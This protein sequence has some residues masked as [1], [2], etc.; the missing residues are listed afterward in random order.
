[1]FDFQ[2]LLTA[3]GW[4][5]LLT[6]I[7]LEM[8]LGIDNLVFIAITTDRLPNNRKVIGRRFGLAAALA[9]RVILLCFASWIISLKIT[10]FTLPFAVPGMDPSFSGKDLILLVGGGYLIFKGIQELLEKLSL[11]EEAEELQTGAHEHKRRISLPQAIGTIALMDMIFSL[12]SVITAVGMVDAILIM[13]LA[14]MI[15]VLVMIVFANV[16]SEFINANPEIKILALAFIVAVGAKLVIEALGFELHIEG[17]SFDGMDLMLYFGLALSLVLTLLQMSYNRRLAKLKVH[18]RSN[19]KE[20]AD[21]NEQALLD[22]SPDELLDESLHELS[23][24]EKIG[25]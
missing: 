13:I 16:I 4:V 21:K 10:L 7:F 6:L 23:E 14:V 8:V 17:S 11:R 22:E 24:Q 19:K 20:Q 18:N 9:M 25:S 3:E 2:V 5:Q 12:D 1:L 15:A